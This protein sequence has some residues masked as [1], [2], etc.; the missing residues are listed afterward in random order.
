MSNYVL[1]ALPSFGPFVKEREAIVARH[2]E[3][4][5]LLS[6]ELEPEKVRPGL[7]PDK[8][9][10]LVKVNRFPLLQTLNKL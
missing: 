4:S 5:D 6:R 1:Q 3:T 7:K 9:V 2:K 8:P 10:P